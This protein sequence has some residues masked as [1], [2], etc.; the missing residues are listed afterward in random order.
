MG[1]RVGDRVAKKRHQASWASGDAR[2]RA[3]AR[4]G[5]LRAPTRLRPE[6]RTDP[7]APAGG[8]L[9][10]Q[11]QIGEECDRVVAIA[12]P[13]VATGQAEGIER[14][15]AADAGPADQGRRVVGPADQ[16]AIREPGP[17]AGP[18]ADVGRVEEVLP[19]PGRPV[20][21]DQ[22]ARRLVEHPQRT[23]QPDH[24]WDRLNHAR[25]D[26]DIGEEGP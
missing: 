11:D 20:G 14:A 7:V 13:T 16:G 10:A 9:A 6:G 19:Q 3:T 8:R 12:A 23:D 26:V 17:P 24:K 5:G 2:V 1:L 15:G 18:A 22:R 4:R 25:A 21:K